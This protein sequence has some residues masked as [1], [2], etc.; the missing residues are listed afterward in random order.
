MIYLHSLIEDQCCVQ[1]E[2]QFLNT[3]N[4]GHLFFTGLN[5]ND[6]LNLLST[7]KKTLMYVILWKN[8][9][10]PVWHVRILFFM[11]QVMLPFYEILAHKTNIV[12]SKGILHCVF[13]NFC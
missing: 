3:K 12:H 11:Y 1:K 7:E 6:R 10:L 13:V 2:N 4:W 5:Q 8:S 9:V